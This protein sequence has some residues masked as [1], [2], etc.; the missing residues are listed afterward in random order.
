MKKIV[1]LVLMGN[2]L[3]NT[4]NSQTHW[5]N[6]VTAYEIFVRSFYDSN[7][8]GIGDFNG[9]NQK[10]NYLNDGNP[11][12]TEDLGVGLVWLMPVHASP[13]YHGYDVTN[14]MQLNPQYGSLNDFKNMLG[15]AHS[16]GIKVIMD[17]VMNHSSDQHPWFVKSAAND[18]FYRNFYRWS[19]SPPSGTGPWGQQLWYPKNGS[20]YYALFWSGMPDLNYD[21]KPVKDSLFAAAKY[22]LQDIGVDG[23]R[24]DAA[25][26]IYEEG[27]VLKNHPKTVAFWKEFNDSC[28]SW[29]DS[30]L[31]VGEI[32]DTPE[33][34]ALYKGKL[35]ICFDFNLAESTLMG[36]NGG[37][38]NAI[39]LAIEQGKQL[40]DSN[41]FA[42]FLTN[43]DQNRVYDVF[44]GNNGKMKAAASALLTQA[45]V[46]FIYYGEEIGMQGAKPDENIRRPMQWSSGANAGFTSGLPWRTINSNYTVYNVGSELADPNSLL[47]HYKKLFG[48]REKNSILQT[49]AHQNMIT[50]HTE[51]MSYYRKLESELVVLINT[52]GLEK[53]GVQFNWVPSE[54]S[55]NASIVYDL[56]NDSSFSVTPSESYY[57]IKINLGPYQTRIMRLGEGT[58]AIEESKEFIGFEIFPNPAKDYFRFEQTGGR[59]INQLEIYSIN[60]EL[61]QTEKIE[62]TQK[63]IRLN[64]KQGIYFVKLGN[65]DGQILFKKLLVE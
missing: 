11:N 1:W 46:P 25:M 43:H 28:K 13:S 49:G 19:N 20:N 22:W 16:K 2:F 65:F 8:D 57:P 56:I 7:G 39:R 59:L 64:L 52:T 32:W 23:F 51:V 33:S 38:A 10:I 44:G 35:D 63:E 4:V 53:I 41:Q 60:G 37:N 17:L 27:S 50:S 62:N 3:S 9:L 61:V 58:N 31:L 18:S 55:K 26:Y 21:Y 48:L 54:K 45:G 15:Q 14:Y 42:S 29:K 6:K 24:L 30:S 34:I 47:N 5:W 12:T 36:I 40:F